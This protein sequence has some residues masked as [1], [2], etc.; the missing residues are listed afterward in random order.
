MQ[1]SLHGP[2]LA[3]ASEIK[4]AN[5]WPCPVPEY[6]DLKAVKAVAD[7]FCGG[8]GEQAERM[9]YARPAMFQRI[10]L[11]AQAEAEAEPHAM[12][13][14]EA[15]SKEKSRAEIQTKKPPGL[16]GTSPT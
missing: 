8:D 16:G 15:K 12:K 13:Y 1:P 4:S 2:S 11:V 6:S 14:A 9:R 7:W 5:R 10:L 3:H